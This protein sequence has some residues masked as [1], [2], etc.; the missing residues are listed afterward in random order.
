MAIK[1]ML[2]Q[3][4][5]NMNKLGLELMHTLNPEVAT[6]TV[7][8][9]QVIDAMAS[10]KDLIKAGADG[11]APTMT[12]YEN[13]VKTTF[14]IPTDIYDALKSN[15]DSFTKLTFKPANAFSNF[16]RNV[17]TQ[18]NP[19]FMVTNAIK[20]SQDVLINSQHPLK[21]YKAIPEAIAQLIS[22]GYWYREMQSQGLFQ[23]T[24]YDNIKGFDTNPKGLAK[25]KEF[26]PLKKISQLND[27]IERV[28]RMA[29]YIASR[30]EGRS[31]EVASLD[32]SRV[33]TNFKA[34]GDFT[35]FLN[36]NGFTFLNASV[37]GATQQVR[38][39]QEA[40][41]QG[42]KG[43]MKLAT[44]FTV[45]A[46]PAV[47]LNSL[48]WGDDDEYEQLNDYIKDNYYIIGK[49]GDG[50]F[51]RIPKGRMTAVIQKGFENMENLITGDDEVDLGNYLEMVVNNLAP[52]NPVENNIL[53]PFI[54]T[55]LF[56]NDDPGKTW[57]G[58]DLIPSRLQDKP[59]A[60][61][62]DETTDEFSKWLGKK[63]NLSPIKINNLIDQNSGV[64]GDLILPMMTAE[65]KTKN[66][67]PIMASIE[68]KFTADIV[69]DNKY[70]SDFY[71]E[72]EKLAKKSNSDNATD[73]DVLKTKFM[74]SIQ[75]NMNDLYK[76]IREIQNSDLDKEIKFNQVREL[77]KQINE[78]A[79]VGL[80]NYE[81]MI[82]NENYASVSNME[83]YKHLDSEGKETWSKI[84]DEEKEALNSMNMSDDDKNN[85]FAAKN[86][87]S[88]IVKD[89]KNDKSVLSDDDEDSYK[90]AVSSLSSEKKAEIINTIK[91]SGL[92]DEGKAYLYDKYYASTDKL[93]VVVSTGIGMDNYLDLE[94]QNF[95]SDKDR[96]GKTISG[97]KKKKVFEYINSTN[98][99]F[100]KKVILAKMY[101]PSY[102]EYNHDIIN[103]L[104]NDNNISYEEEEEILKTLGFKVDS[105]G[106]VRW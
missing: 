37:Q 76:E 95:Q 80:N 9:D 73:E 15:N 12:V 24:Y 43:Y 1:T 61:Q 22:K 102:N 69:F 91:N 18:Y 104:N 59:A 68:D 8:A 87:I 84:N 20:D 14:E 2:V 98:L 82:A 90:E 48:L 66:S 31:M 3:R 19:F 75:S 40:H 17:L 99:D 79:K 70:S 85:Y 78:M 27:F 93:N 32:A 71:T 50:Q 45:A 94:A 16:K 33:T 74:N 60:E 89:Y 4:S 51:I 88:S 42:L 92:D 23:D 26:Y 67:N 54:N 49:Y 39:I 62:Y 7:T 38:N 105:N 25:I 36:R 106:N 13:G 57:Y 44:K 29:E 10:G 30:K 81:D 97:S 53:S 21:T 56:N 101:Y 28:P 83:Y 72:K 47:I 77:K 52:S 5:V 58:S 96:Q 86:T 65:A 100:E 55:K 64:I 41:A 11:K 63:L 34:S 103:Y 6:E 46:L 35:K